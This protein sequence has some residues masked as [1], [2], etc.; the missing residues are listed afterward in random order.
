MKQKNADNCDPTQLIDEN[1]IKPN[2]GNS[3]HHCPLPHR[4]TFVLS[5]EQVNILYLEEEIPSPCQSG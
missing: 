3:F 5:G 2:T 1:D 4:N